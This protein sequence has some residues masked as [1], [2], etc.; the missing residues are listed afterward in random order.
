MVDRTLLDAVRDS[1]WIASQREIKS[2]SDREQLESTLPVKSILTSFGATVGIPLGM[3]G[4]GI[5][6]ILLF[7]RRAQQFQTSNSS[8]SFGKYVLSELCGCVLWLATIQHVLPR[9]YRRKREKY[10]P[11]DTVLGIISGIGIVAIAVGTWTGSSTA[12][13]GPA[14]GIGHPLLVQMLV[15]AGSL[16]LTNCITP[17]VISMWRGANLLYP[18]MIRLWVQR[19]VLLATLPV[20]GV[21]YFALMLALL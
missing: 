1:K 9:L 11:I 16:V 20:I 3:I 8:A 5:V 7:A 2:W 18:S 6:L 12:V 14:G 17:E 15:A 21:G 4:I 10:E 19:M 13:R